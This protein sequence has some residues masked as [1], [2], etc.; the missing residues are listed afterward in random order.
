MNWL[1]K[2]KFKNDVHKNMDWNDN[3]KMDYL[4]RKN[5]KEFDFLNS[6]NEEDFI[7]SSIDKKR[8]FCLKLKCDDLYRDYWTI[9]YDMVEKDLKE[10]RKIKL[11]ELH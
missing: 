10:T 11:N 6:V 1:K 7:K 3:G 9:S 5:L 4:I 8:C 2:Y